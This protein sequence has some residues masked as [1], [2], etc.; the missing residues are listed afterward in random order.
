MKRTFKEAMLLA[1][2]LKV[3]ENSERSASD[4][5]WFVYVTGVDNSARPAVYEYDKQQ[6]RH[7]QIAA[8]DYQD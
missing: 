1:R 5:Q 3:K 6:G 4:R 2:K 8:F 7:F